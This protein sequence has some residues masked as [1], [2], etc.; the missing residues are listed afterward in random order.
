MKVL[1]IGG[2]LCCCL[3]VVLIVGG[4]CH[5]RNENSLKPTIAWVNDPFVLEDFEYSLW[6][7]G[8]KENLYKE[9]TVIG[10][11]I[12]LTDKLFGPFSIGLVKEMTI[13]EPRVMFYDKNQVVAQLSAN[14]AMPRLDL[15]KG[16][17]DF[18][19]AQRFSF[20]QKPVLVGIN[21]RSMYCQTLEWNREA[22]KIEGQ[23]DCVLNLE[24]SVVQSPHVVV[25]IDLKEWQVLET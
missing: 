1:L 10:K 15:L 9:F 8:Q 16:D 21:G 25:S 2:L 12:G 18:M 23:G 22:G 19:Q 6:L 5:F 11:R 4:V 7:P 14:Q 24:D 3:S 20:S 17:V 13:K